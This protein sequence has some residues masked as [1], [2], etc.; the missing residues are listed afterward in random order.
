M[1]GLVRPPTS[2]ISLTKLHILF[3]F[4]SM[5]NVHLSAPLLK[6]INV[7]KVYI[8]FSISTNHWSIAVNLDHNLCNKVLFE[9][10]THKW[11][12]ST[13]RRL[14]SIW[15]Q[16]VPN[17]TD[18]VWSKKPAGKSGFYLSLYE[19]F[20]PGRELTVI[21]LE[22]FWFAVKPLNLW[23]YLQNVCT[24]VYV[25]ICWA[26]RPRLFCLPVSLVELVWNGL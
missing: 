8:F 5:H 16:T 25:S 12:A 21:E 7:D 10:C 15:K 18:P 9:N 19:R 6:L 22:N 2:L 11:W 14:Q 23:I 17:F 24:F 3:Y 4:F 1:L 13:F 26:M 20:L